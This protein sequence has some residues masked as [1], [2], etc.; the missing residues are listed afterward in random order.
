MDNDYWLL[1]HCKKY[2]MLS[3]MCMTLEIYGTTRHIMKCSSWHFDGWHKWSM[4]CMPIRSTWDHQKKF[5]LMAHSLVYCI[6]FCGWV[7]CVRRLMLIYIML[8]VLLRLMSFECTI[9]I[10]RLFVWHQK[11][12]IEMIDVQLEHIHAKHISTVYCQPQ[13]ATNSIILFHFIYKHIPS[14]PFL[15][16][17][18]YIVSMQTFSTEETNK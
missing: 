12:R 10:F 7:Y 14:T 5:Y 3:H 2:K 1:V 17:Y 4:I 15:M 6:L 16:I 9:W 13:F 8:L 11:R 18:Y